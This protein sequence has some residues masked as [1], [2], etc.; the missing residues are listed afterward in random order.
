[1]LRLTQHLTTLEDLQNNTKHLEIYY[2]VVRF[3]HGDY[4]G[5]VP[6]KTSDMQKRAKPK[7]QVQQQLQLSHLLQQLPASICGFPAPFPS[8]HEDVAEGSGG[9]VTLHVFSIP[10]ICG[11]FLWTKAAL[12]F[13]PLFPQRQKP[14]A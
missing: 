14:F 5:N 2:K 13:S 7:K 10:G 12:C 3:H 1:M 8:S 4:K 6:F 9:S 11:R